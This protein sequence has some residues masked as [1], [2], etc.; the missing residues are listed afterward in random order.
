MDYQP[1]RAFTQLITST[2]ARTPNQERL[3]IVF[4]GEAGW[5]KQCESAL[6]FLPCLREEGPVDIAVSGKATG[7]GWHFS[8]NGRRLTP[9]LR[10]FFWHANTGAHPIELALHSENALEGSLRIPPV[11][12]YHWREQHAAAIEALPVLLINAVLRRAGYSMREAEPPRPALPGSPAPSLPAVKWFFLKKAVRSLYLTLPYTTSPRRW[13]I[14][15]HRDAAGS[16][17]TS[18]W[19]FIS[20]FPGHEAADP[21]LA[22]HDGQ[23]Y[24]IYEDMLPVTRHGRLAAMPAFD[25]AARPEV[26]LE[27][28]YHLSYPFVFQHAGD[29]WMIPE[30]SENRT[31]DL[32][33]AIR[34]PYQWEH[35]RTLMEGAALSDTT[36]F[37]YEGMWYFFTTCMLPGRA[38]MGLLFFAEALDAP[39]RLHPSSPLSGDAAIAR[40]AGPIVQ[41][42]GKLVRPV[43]D[44]ALT[45]G[46]AVTLFEIQELTPTRLRE[47]KR[48]QIEP[49]WQKNLSGTHTFCSLGSMLA[50]DARR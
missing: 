5:L 29:W 45:Y 42:N 18:G 4:E 22:T 39:W 2:A 31:V 26:I 48:L 11:P 33:R 12:G 30:S 1:F 49:T 44:C 13:S 19:Q 41:W 15:L 14:A 7:P 20:G 3:R 8:L 23:H 6:L 46:R 38:Y 35:S 9:D 17:P 28:P 43:Q 34:F 36:P 37:L 27:K 24:L 50:M 32:Y 16:I 21:F 10:E 47:Q 40:A 25:A